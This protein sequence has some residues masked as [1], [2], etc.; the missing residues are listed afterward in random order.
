MTKVLIVDDEMLVRIGIKSL[1]NWEENGFRLV[2]DAP[3]GVS[4]LELIEETLPEI[5]ITDIVM[6]KLNGLKLIEIIKGKYPFIKVIVLSCHNDFQYVRQAMKLGAEDY[7]LKLSMQPE[8][9]LTLLKNV[10]GMISQDNIK[11]N[12]IKNDADADKKER[13]DALKILME[14]TASHDTIK[15]VALKLTSEGEF[16]RVYLALLKIDGVNDIKD[17]TIMEKTLL[18]FV[19]HKVKEYAEGDVFKHR[20]NEYAI[21]LY[22]KEGGI[23]KEINGFLKEIQV[24][25]RRFLNVSVSAGM[26]LPCKECSL[27]KE[28][29]M[30]AKTALQFSFY[31]GAGSICRYSPNL[32]GCNPRK[33]WSKED[34]KKLYQYLELMELSGAR[35]YMEEFFKKL[36]T[37]R[38][39]MEETILTFMEILYCAR[40]LLGSNGIDITEVLQTKELYYRQIQ[41]FEFLDGAKSWFMILM[42]RC[43]A[44]V[45]KVKAEKYRTEI[46]KLTEY[47]KVNYSLNLSLG[48]A[49]EFV[50]MNECY[51]SHIFKKETGKSLI[52]YLTDLRIKKAVELLKSTDLTSYEIAVKVGYENINYFGR[53]FKRYMGV[54]PSRF[55]AKFQ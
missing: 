1:I 11:N 28:A 17:V 16:D 9:L 34:E 46:L 50:H 32:F 7:L 2:G 31:T 14:G 5:V 43:L 25:V 41:S 35:S 44:A 12:R 36:K 37:A 42:E 38:L 6:P 3:D 19:G 51:L 18:N 33:L 47:L 54:S 27:L 49:A 24:S 29:Y 15:N 26:G 48:W 20:D 30:Q 53:I 55:R 45:E 23:A 13:E 4:A 21:I 40:K 22:F 8:E 52:E 10:K 39:P